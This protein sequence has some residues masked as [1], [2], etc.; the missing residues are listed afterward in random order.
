M[1]RP[2]REHLLKCAEN[3]GFKPLLFRNLQEFN[4]YPKEPLFIRLSDGEFIEAGNPFCADVGAKY[5]DIGDSLPDGLVH[6]VCYAHDDLLLEYGRNWKDLRKGQGF[7][8]SD[9][10]AT[11]RG[12]M[13]GVTFGLCWPSKILC[14]PSSALSDVL[15]PGTRSSPE[16][17]SSN[18][19]ENLDIVDLSPQTLSPLQNTQQGN[20]RTSATTK[21]EISNPAFYYPQTPQPG[22][23][24]PNTP[25]TSD[26]TPST[27]GTSD[28]VP[29]TPGTSGTMPDVPDVPEL[30]GIRRD[31]GSQEM[32]GFSQ[33]DDCSQVNA[34]FATTLVADSSN[35]WGPVERKR[36]ALKISCTSAST[37]RLN[38]SKRHS[39]SEARNC[40]KRCRYR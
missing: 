31:D 35:S 28:T 13:K 11:L 21:K 8:L 40:S 9:P 27:P 25:G 14:E 34:S 38:N 5:I 10:N 18:N 24:V 6:I 23:T 36:R 16:Y 15:L 33:G 2:R 3:V 29:N 37:I 20:G 32:A 12:T 39:P 22:E 30:A 17:N 26:T 4:I 7:A 1:E 19:D